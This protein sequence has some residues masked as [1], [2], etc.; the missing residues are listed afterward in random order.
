[1]TEPMTEA[2]HQRFAREYRSWIAAG[3]NPVAAHQL[4]SR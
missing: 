3:L 1:M 4:A 2:Q